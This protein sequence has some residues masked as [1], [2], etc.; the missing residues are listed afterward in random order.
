ML[1]ALDAF[2]ILFF[3][4][5]GELL[6]ILD[7]RLN[8]QKTAPDFITKAL[9]DIIAAAF[10]EKVLEPWSSASS[11]FPVFPGSFSIAKTFTS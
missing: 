11:G 3:N 8:Q 5:S 1:M 4:M 2:P 9:S 6:Y 10:H 7:E